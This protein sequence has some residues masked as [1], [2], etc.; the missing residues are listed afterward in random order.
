MA[1]LFRASAPL[2]GGS[3]RLPAHDLSLIHIFFFCNS[4]AEAN[5][6]CIKLARRYMR[7][8][9]QRD[10][11]EIITLGGCFHGRTDVYKRQLR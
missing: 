9:K 7:K 10:A 6:A 1:A 5:E 11:Y 2:G 3:G 8:V 4:G